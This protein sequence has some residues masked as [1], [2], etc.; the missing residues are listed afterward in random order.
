MIARPAIGNNGFGM[1]KLKG[2]SRVPFEGPPISTTALEMAATIFQLTVM[3][4]CRSFDESNEQNKV[5]DI[6]S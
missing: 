3:A 1:S 2:R 5:F 4:W 6:D